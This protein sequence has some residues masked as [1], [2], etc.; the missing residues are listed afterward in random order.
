MMQAYPG[1]EH[2]EV[3]ATLRHC[4][5][6]RV[7]HRLEN[8]FTFPDGSRGWFDLNIQPVP[9]GIFI[10]SHDV[11]DRKRAES[12][13]QHQ[14]ERLGALRA[15]DIAIISSLDL[16][17]TLSVFLDQVVTQLGVHAADVLML[18]PDTRMLT[19]A[20]GRGFRTSALQQ[21]QQ[22]LGEGNAGRAALE[23]RIVN[24]PDLRKAGRQFRRTSLL[25]GD[26]FVSYFGVPLISK[27]EVKGVLEIFHRAPLKPD[28][29]WQSFLEALAGQAAIAVDNAQLFA[30]LQRTNTELTL[31][32]D[33]TIEGWSRALDLRDKETEGHSQR[34][35]DGHCAWRAPWA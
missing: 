8:E 14:L 22:R 2:T 33:E 24:V 7:A 26:D 29:E 19:Y 12:Q 11:T 15:I 34:V 5:E 25:V 9:E 17:L 23:R 13:I 20:A 1:I 3:F 10:L 6:Q 27:G 18:E 28:P 21:V 32:Y 16:R 35:T 4:M 31:S 30:N